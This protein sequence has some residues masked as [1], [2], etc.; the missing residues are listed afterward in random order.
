MKWKNSETEYTRIPVEKISEHKEDSILNQ[1]DW[2]RKILI[3]M[4]SSMQSVPLYIL[5][6]QEKI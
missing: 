4:H 3:S 1:R 5:K 6:A 2:T